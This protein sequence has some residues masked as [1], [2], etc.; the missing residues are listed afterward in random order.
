[1]SRRNL[2]RS[3]KTLHYEKQR[4]V[5]LREI[6]KN[7]LHGS[8]RREIAGDASRHFVH[9]NLT[10]KYTDTYLLTYTEFSYL[11]NAHKPAQIAAIEI[12]EQ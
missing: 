5:Y 8:R 9:V 1:M 4:E 3:I 12:Q 2:R 6:S 7:T 10:T 11:T